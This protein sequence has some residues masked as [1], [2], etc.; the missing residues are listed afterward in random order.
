MN[1]KETEKKLKY[2]K[3]T[4]AAVLIGLTPAALAGQDADGF[5]VWADV[6][7]VQPIVSTGYE[8]VPVTSCRNER[9][10]HRVAYRYTDDDRRHRDHR[11]DDGALPA[12]VGGVLGGAIGNQ[13]GSGNGRRA[14]TVVGAILGASIAASGQDRP[15]HETHDRR[16]RVCETTY[17]REAYSV[18][19]GYDVTYRYMGRE[20]EKTT[21]EHP[22]QRIKLYVTVDPVEDTVI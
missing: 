3:T 12:L 1:K 21:Q 20:F 10:S 18:V 2:L 22:G 8:R 17:E 9:P 11:S 5:F 19:E 14:M 4:V 15:R 6:T 16:A 7:D 13:F